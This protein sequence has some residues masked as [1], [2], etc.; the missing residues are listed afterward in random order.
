M[1]K[2]IN[3]FLALI[4]LLCIFTFAV[5]FSK[6]NVAAEEEITRI[7][8][9]ID[10]DKFDYYFNVAFTEGKLSE[11]L[12]D[13]LDSKYN[14]KYY[15]DKNNTYIMYCYDE[16]VKDSYH[17]YYG[18]GDGTENIRENTTYVIKFLLYTDNCSFGENL[19]VYLNDELQDP[20]H[21]YS[22]T[23]YFNRF[24]DYG[25]E[26]KIS[27]GMPS[28][29]KIV[30][31]LEVSADEK[32]IV[33]GENDTFTATVFGNVD[34]KTIDWSLSGN[35][36]AST[37]V[38]NGV[39][40]I[41]EDET[42]EIVTV[43]AAAHANP[44]VYKEIKIYVLSEKPY[45]ES[46]DIADIA[47]DHA[48]GKYLSLN[49]TVTGTHINKEVNW[50]VEG[51]ESA[52]TVIDEYGYLLIAIDETST[53]IT[54]VATSQ[55]DD[56]K[57]D[58][59]VFNITPAQKLDEINVILDQNVVNDYLTGEYTEGDFQEK[60]RE[61]ASVSDGLTI[62]TNNTFLNYEAS[63]GNLY[64]IGWGYSNVSKDRQYA[65]SF[66]ILTTAGYYIADDEDTFKFN[67]VVTTPINY[68]VSNSGSQSL[69]VIAFYINASD[70]VDITV[71][72]VE[73][74]IASA[75]RT[76]A[77][78]GSEI[79][80]T[81][82]PD[83]N[84]VF[85]EWQ[86]VSGNVEIVNNK[87]IIGNESV[88]IKPVY[89]PAYQ[90]II[91]SNG[92]GNTQ[93]KDKAVEGEEVIIDL[94]P[95][96]G[97][98]VK[99]IEVISGDVVLDGNTFIMGNKNVVINVVYSKILYLTITG[100]ED[101]SKGHVTA[102]IDRGTEGMEV[103]LTPSAQSG[104]QFIKF[105]VVSGGI[106]IEDNKFT[107]G[108]EDVNIYAVFEALKGITVTSNQY[109]TASA[110]IV[111]ALS[112]TKVTLTATPK[113][114]CKFIKWVVV[115]GDVTI[116]DNQF[117][118][119]EEPVVIRADF[120]PIVN[121]TVINDGNGEGTVDVATGVEGDV[122]TLTATPNQGYA[123]KEWII[124]E[125][126]ASLS[127][128]QLT[129]G[130]TNVTVKAVFEKLY[131]ITV[132]NDGNGTAEANYASATSGTLVTL[133]ATPKSGYYLKEYQVISGGITVSVNEFIVLTD[134]IEIKAIFAQ[135]HVCA[136]TIVEKV[137]STCI[138][139]GKQA[140]YKCTC[141]LYYE[142]ANA[143][144]IINNISTWGII[145]VK[146]HT[147]S[148]WLSDE[149]NHWKE[150]TNQ[151]CDHITTEKTAHTPNIPSAT[152]EEAKVCTVC[153]YVME[154]KLA[155]QHKFEGDWVTDEN[156]HWKECSCGEAI[157]QKT[158]H[159]PNIPSATEKEAKV[160]TECG[161]VMEEKLAHQHKFEGDWVTDENNHWK[162]CACGEA[163]DQKGAHTPNIPSATE[164]EAKVC[165][166]CGYVME[167]KLVHQHKYEGD[168]KTNKDF[169]W[170]ECSCGKTE[171]K[172]LHADSNGDSKCDVCGA[173]VVAEKP[174]VDRCLSLSAKLVVLILS[175]ATLFSCVLFKRKH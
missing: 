149:N 137:D 157:D 38:S 4:T 154:E 51:A 162:E 19:E 13:M 78:A 46:V 145:P 35:T 9:S 112:G 163:I 101:V 62:N 153:G 5:K 40:T 65:I 136:P 37:V 117:V 94:Y 10:Q 3:L 55:A 138:K 155:H 26:F 159:T 75:N 127:N 166:V 84:H 52:N 171:Q 120:L 33:K 168:W 85:K 28:T 12:D 68:E 47:V 95:T 82:I 124:T 21:N 66:R 41:G 76:T 144:V 69:L 115:S 97:Y 53:K 106:T 158:A 96:N 6:I 133:T 175:T 24:G 71:Q 90:V 49:V 161:Y 99:S 105:V 148:D 156:N 169:H 77:I 173:N 174:V 81:V 73:G 63:P 30:T 48:A 39:V 27:F 139:E 150:C 103:T 87:F 152:E 86:V 93:C 20:L 54:I 114:N 164:E 118:M 132:L 130:T 88:V 45:I 109:G 116:T 60:I 98:M 56:T 42:A 64:G 125:G 70:T 119:G 102:S 67:G 25:V 44:S 43:K 58:S 104:Y 18:T 31:G 11:M 36:S 34:D 140:Y 80:L 160:C 111:D 32:Q 72:D 22:D 50:S 142:D 151:G 167:E 79:T 141:G 122:L 113:E 59:V 126:T 110:D 91:N 170:K 29:E 61:V 2:S 15:I 134:N 8:L 89:L 23:S 14:D 7:D 135:E 107:F 16:A 57:K 123:F 131:T 128:N 143:T 108:M 129:L 83:S 146:E 121:V 100:N 147:S 172:A 1:K 17:G 74:G 92:P 165:T